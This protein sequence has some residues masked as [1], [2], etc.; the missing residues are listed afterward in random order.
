MTRLFDENAR[1]EYLKK[2]KEELLY[3]NIP[4]KDMI[5]KQISVK[6]ARPYIATYHYSKTMP[7]S[8]KFVFAGYFDN[9]LAGIIVYGMGAGKS[10]YTSIIPTIKTGEYIELTRLWSPDGMPKNTES[11][12]IGESIKQLPNN[13]KMIISFSDEQQKHVGTIYQATNF[14]YLGQNNGGKM[15]ID[16]NGIIKHPRLLGIYKKRHPLTYGKM[17]NDVLMQELNFRYV[18]GGKKHRYVIFKGDKR[19]KKELFKYIKDRIQ[20][21]PKSN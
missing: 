2:N 14:Y 6:E 18:D 1:L 9:K 4:V 16:N 19:I 13:I 12:L 11:K 17:T 7:D 21:Y 20:K 10:Q 8:S 3:N 5:V 15:L